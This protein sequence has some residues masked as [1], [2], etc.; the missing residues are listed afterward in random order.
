MRTWHP[1]DKFIPLGM[2]QYKKLSDYFIDKKIPSLFRDK[3]PLVLVKGEIACVGGFA[4]ADPFKIRGQGNCLKITR[5]TQGAQDW[6][7]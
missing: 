4:V 7:W 5:Q 2:S 6:T 1:G 3:I